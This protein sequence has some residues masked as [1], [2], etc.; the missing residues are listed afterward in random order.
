MRVF[1]TKLHAIMKVIQSCN[2]W[3]APVEIAKRL[4]NNWS[5]HL[6]LIF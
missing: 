6:L 4:N 5:T 2:A 1:D 3:H